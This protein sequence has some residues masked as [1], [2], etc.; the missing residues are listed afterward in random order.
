MLQN[1]TVNKMSVWNPL[2][3]YFLL[4]IQGMGA[5]MPG[6]TLIYGKIK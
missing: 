2:E 4:Q 6:E 5:S 1:I 3:R